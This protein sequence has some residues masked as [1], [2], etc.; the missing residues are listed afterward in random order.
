MAKSWK[1]APE[2][3][4]MSD[5]ALS[6]TGSAARFTPTN[7]GWKGFG[8]LLEDEKVARELPALDAKIKVAGQ[9]WT[10]GPRGQKNYVG[11]TLLGLCG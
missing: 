8:Q 1:W 3:K 2:P 7:V 5:E 4:T 10:L 11:T 6:G 9:Y